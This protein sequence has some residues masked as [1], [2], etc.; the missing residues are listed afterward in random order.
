M[1]S[2]SFAVAALQKNKGGFWGMGYL[3]AL[4]AYWVIALAASLLLFLQSGAYPRPCRAWRQGY[5]QLSFSGFPLRRLRLLGGYGV[6]L[7]AVPHNEILPVVRRMVKT[8]ARRFDLL[9]AHIGNMK[10]APRRSDR[11][12]RHKAFGVASGCCFSSCPSL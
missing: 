9:P 5:F 4:G 10:I 1:P 7:C 12:T 3:A 2:A 11:F 6:S 8:K